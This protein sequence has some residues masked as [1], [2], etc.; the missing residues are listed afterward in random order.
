MDDALKPR[1]VGEFRSSNGPSAAVALR[2][3]SRNLS[4]DS[5]YTAYGSQPDECNAGG[6][7]ADADIFM[8]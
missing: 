1:Q 3:S 7:P 4:F 8:K 5:G 6:V 2:L